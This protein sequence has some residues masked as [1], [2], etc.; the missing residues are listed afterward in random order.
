MFS[1]VNIIK[2]IP[3]DFFVQDNFVYYQKKNVIIKCRSNNE[4]VL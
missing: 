3:F 2:N 1:I 4:K